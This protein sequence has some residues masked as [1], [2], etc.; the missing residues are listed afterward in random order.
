MAVQ[1]VSIVSP[2]SDSHSV[3][4][5]DEITLM[6]TEMEPSRDKLNGNPPPHRKGIKQWSET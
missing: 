4:K 5:V 6:E 3:T 2:I 1:E